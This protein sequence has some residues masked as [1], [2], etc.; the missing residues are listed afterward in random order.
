MEL[1]RIV[2]ILDI[3]EEN[4]D[5]KTI[6]FEDDFEAYPGQFVMVWIPSV[7]EVPMSVSYLGEKK[8]IT[9]KNVGK[10][11]SSLCKLKPGDKIGIRGPHGTFFEATG[12]SLL[13]VAGGI[14]IAPL[15]PLMENAH[16]IGKQI[17]LA[18]GAKSKSE[19]L[20]I[21]RLKGCSR[22]L[23]ISTDD[24]SLGFHGFVSDLV[25]DILKKQSFDEI[26]CCGPEIMIKKIA[27]LAKLN[28]IPLQASLERYMKCGVGICDSCAIDGFHVCIDGPVFS[29][30]ILSELAD[31]GRFRRDAC[32]RR[33]EL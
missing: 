5:V 26:L 30:K 19:L 14:G 31:F 3:V 16:N 25:E 18:F 33:V 9:V 6:F 12:D 28:G 15:A 29:G 23:N 13:V 27:D 1:P 2:K 21:N 10:A 17:T 7:D 8:G 24:G 22:E 4:P 20:F 11:T 32:G